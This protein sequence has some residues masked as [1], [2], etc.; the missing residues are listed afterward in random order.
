LDVDEQTIGSPVYKELVG[1]KAVDWSNIKRSRAKYF[2][3]VFADWKSRVEVAKLNGR[4]GDILTLADDAPD[5]L[6]SEQAALG[7][8]R[9]A[10]QHGAFQRREGR[11]RRLLVVE[12]KHRKAQTQLGLA[13]GL[14]GHD[15]RSQSPHAWS[16]R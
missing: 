16:G 11:A 1:L 15:K 2:G 14:S 3:E 12:P 9:R 10:L 8:R 6:S 5:T 13:L 4:P 7:G